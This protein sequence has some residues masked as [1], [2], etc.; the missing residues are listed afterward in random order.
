MNLEKMNNKK[1]AET[2]LY[3]LSKYFK[4]Q[5]AVK[6]YCRIVRFL[7]NNKFPG[8]MSLLSFIGRGGGFFLF[9][10]R[11][12]SYVTS[13]VDIFDLLIFSILHFIPLECLTLTEQYI[14]IQKTYILHI[15]LPPDNLGHRQS[16]SSLG[17]L[18]FPV[19]YSYAFSYW[20]KYL[21]AIR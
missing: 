4:Y 10:K 17:F 8:I 12:D 16:R 11:G 20:L 6:R 3:Q 14:N 2:P 5:L 13:I 18:H 1:I 15:D 9:Y 7:F 19:K 21:K